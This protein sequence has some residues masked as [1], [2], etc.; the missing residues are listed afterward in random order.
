MP[1]QV[2]TNVP[3]NKVE[4]YTQLYLNAGATSVT[5]APET[6]GEVTLIIVY[7]D[8]DVLEA[9]VGGGSGSAAAPLDSV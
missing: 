1:T 8:H 3:A 9:M 5:P 7:P 4:S 2:I 6:D